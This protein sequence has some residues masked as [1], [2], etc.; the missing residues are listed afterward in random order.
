[1]KRN[2]GYTLV[3]TLGVVGLLTTIG[4]LLIGPSQTEHRRVELHYRTVQA[5]Y[6]SLAGIEQAKHWAAQGVLTNELYLLANGAI[7]TTME[8]IDATTCRVVSHGRVH[9]SWKKGLVIVRSEQAVPFRPQQDPTRSK[10]PL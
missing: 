1:M 3:F 7:D 4:A 5:Q 6:L 10:E 2:Q 9:S 8:P